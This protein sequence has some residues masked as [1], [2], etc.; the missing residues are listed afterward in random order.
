MLYDF[1]IGTCAETTVMIIF[2]SMNLF[3]IIIGALMY[4]VAIY[5]QYPP[6]ITGFIMGHVIGNALFFAVIVFLF[7]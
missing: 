7:V 6:F 3:A 5:R 4:S 1:F 2:L